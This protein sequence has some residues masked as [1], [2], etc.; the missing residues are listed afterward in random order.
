MITLKS[1]CQQIAIKLMSNA[2]NVCRECTYTASES[3]KQITIQLWLNCHSLRD[4]CMLSY[5]C[6]AKNN[7]FMYRIR[8]Y[9]TFRGLHKVPPLTSCTWQCH[10]N[11][12][13]C[14][15]TESVWHST[16]G[17][18]IIWYNRLR[19]WLKCDIWN[20]LKVGGGTNNT[21]APLPKKWG[22]RRLCVTYCG[23]VVFRRWW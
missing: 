15:H 2:Y 5:T 22:F 21:E 4:T 14:S 16:A 12:F 7:K 11:V 17:N 19:A 20:G 23:N 3:R 9:E 6:Y 1:S 10:Y 18:T 8:P 13:F